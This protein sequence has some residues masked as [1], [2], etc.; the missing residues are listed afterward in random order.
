MSK[1]AA[2]IPAGGVGLRMGLDMPKQFARLADRPILYHTLMAFEQ[3]ACI[4]FV[5]L[6][7]PADYVGP[8]QKIVSVNNFS[9]PIKVMPGGILRMD[10]VRIGLHN[11]PDGV[12]IVV[13]H[14]GVRPLV[15]PALIDACVQAAGK[16]GAALAAIP[17]KDTVK[18]VGMDSLVEKTVDRQGLWLAQT[19]QAAHFKLLQ[20]AYVAADKDGFVGTDEASLLEFAGLP[21]A[22]VD[23]SEKN[24]KITR[25]EDLTI[26]EA[27]LMDKDN[28]INNGGRGGQMRI[29]H[30]YDAHQLVAGRDLVLGGVHIPHELGLLGHSD[31]DVLLHA[32]C[33]AI[34]GALA[35][36]DIGRH[37]P[38]T[39]QTYK[40]ISSLVLLENVMAKAQEKGCTLANCDIT[41]VAQRPKLL[42]YI[43]QMRANVSAACGVEVDRI[44]IKA[45][46]TEKMG[47]AGREE[48]IA[49]HAVVLLQG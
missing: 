25:P 29:G 38:D 48:G 32:L 36:G 9:K 39:D 10:S 15:S 49:A 46:S 42:P 35:L 14:D 4:D 22:I 5:I 3:A 40:G 33:D 44:N 41:V 12:E 1:N 47:F 11:L 31:A 24:I 37:F 21:V 2:I 43:D 30:G 26:A 28:T 23:G 16:F 27:L 18:A 34:L 7:V 20:K 13:V 8:A 19:P 17:V 6:L 45:T